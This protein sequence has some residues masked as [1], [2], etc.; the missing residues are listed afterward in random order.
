MNT[1]FA[2]VVHF[3]PCQRA[4]VGGRRAHWV[5]LSRGARLLGE[6]DPGRIRLSC[7]IL[8]DLGGAAPGHLEGPAESAGDL[9]PVYPAGIVILLPDVPAPVAAG[10]IRLWGWT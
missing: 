5:I 8:R 7:Q 2:P 10:L 4:W 6:R 9:G 1:S 3:L